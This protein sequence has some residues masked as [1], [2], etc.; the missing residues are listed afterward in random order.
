METARIDNNQV[1]S[2]YNDLAQTRKLSQTST[3]SSTYQIEE[4]VDFNC[5]YDHE[6]IRSLPRRNFFGKV[7]NS[8]TRACHFLK[9]L[10][11]ESDY[12]FGD[13]PLGNEYRFRDW[14]TW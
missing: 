12:S 9:K 3:S 2:G 6:A 4:N 8:L 13:Y 11:S 5:N 7:R 1:S 10:D 14:D